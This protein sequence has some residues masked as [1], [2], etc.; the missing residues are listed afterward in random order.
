MFIHDSEFSIYYGL[1][2][3]LDL[4]SCRDGWLGIGDGVM[5]V[6]TLGVCGR[7]VGLCEQWF[8]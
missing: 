8:R 5:V 7:W 4:G 1:C 2:V 3:G 6:R